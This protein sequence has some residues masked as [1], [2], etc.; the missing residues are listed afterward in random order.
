MNQRATI[1]NEPKQVEHFAGAGTG[2]KAMKALAATLALMASSAAAAQECPTCS[3]ADACIKTYLKATADAQKATRQGIRDWK[4]NLD[5]K[6][7]AEFSSKGTLA[8]QDAMESQIRLELERLKE[9][10][11]K[12]R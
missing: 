8:L 11:A 9:C 3:M 6:A 10:L 12:I 5:K 2:R 7:S 4:Q 1:A